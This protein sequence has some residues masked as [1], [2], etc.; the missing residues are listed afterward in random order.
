MMRGMISFVYE[1][2]KKH[3]SILLLLDFTWN[4]EYEFCLNMQIITTNKYV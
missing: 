4:Q 1:L 2:F 3:N